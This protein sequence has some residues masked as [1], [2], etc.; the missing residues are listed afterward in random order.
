MKYWKRFFFSPFDPLPLSM[1]RISLGVLI[2]MA[3]FCLAPNW[4]A[5][6]SDNGVGGPYIDSWSIFYFTKGVIPLDL[7]WWIAVAAS[8]GFTLGYKTRV[9]TIVLYILEVS[10]I[11]SNRMIVNGED[12]TCRMLLFY[13]CFTDLGRALS[14][15]AWLK[16]KKKIPVSNDP[17][18]WPVAWPIRLMQIN[19]ALIYVI[20]LP[21]KIVDDHA[22]LTGDAI[23]LSIVSNMWSRWP[24]PGIFYGGMLSKIM[25]YMTVLAEGTF[26]VLVWFNKTK[27]YS[28]ALLASLHIGIAI[29]LQNVTFFTLSMVASLCMFIPG[30]MLRGWM[31]KVFHQGFSEL[32]VKEAPVQE[33]TQRGPKAKPGRGRKGRRRR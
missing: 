26:P 31:D 33:N 11:H 13:S 23:Y 27:M 1:F 7:F 9:C 4:N 17:S 22:W 28:I 32:L 20:S 29:M 21:N 6:Y 25:T 2:T 18:A 14:L 5:Y 15:D 8:L 12:F 30:K 3:Y 16:A 10:M 24:W 19:F